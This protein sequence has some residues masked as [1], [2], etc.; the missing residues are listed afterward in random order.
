MTMP[1]RFVWSLAALAALGA[2][3]APPA[4]GQTA[5]G[6]S[7]CDP[8]P[9]AVEPTPAIAPAEICVTVAVL[10]AD[11]MEG[12]LAGSVG[13]EKAAAYL[14]DRFAALGLEAPGGSYLQPFRF[15]AAVFRDP[16][17]AADPATAGDSTIAAANVV[18]I[19]RGRDPALAEQAVVVGA[20]YDHLGW[21]GQ[22]S[23]LPGERA[24][25]N[26]ADDNASGVAGILELA[27]HFRENPPRRTLVFVAFGAEE[28]GTLGSQR[29][30]REPAWPLDRTVAMVNLDMVGRLR[31]RLD[32][33]GTGSSPAW[34]A[35]LDSLAALPGAPEIARVPDGMGPS[36]HASFYVS[37]I[38]VLF[39]FTGAHDDYHRP[40]DDVERIDA[41]GEA[42]VLE[43]A[44]AAIG[45]IAD[46]AEPPAFSE[47][48]ITQ[49]RAVAFNVALGIV[50]DYGYAEGG[51]RVSSVRPG[52]PAELAGLLADDVLVELA[53][54]AVE[55]VYAYT[56]VLGELEAGVS[57]EAVV[58]RG[59]DTVRLTVV[60]EPR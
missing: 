54:R 21:G 43:L 26:G 16:H 27:H 31:E 45:A 11:S 55:D 24:I 38:P 42:R 33:Q 48:P 58:R 50:P 9:P 3:A 7:I 41:G 1:R 53:G 4:S 29:Y 22:G 17:A 14:A 23:L 57:V 13:S 5:E 19:L 15:A 25:H 8:A 49:R 18:A 51:V 10:A 6:S 39:F 40:S 60:P 59:A 56:A 36:D 32:V 2:L 37:R 34:T 35:L 20:H 52:G 28:L 12:R 44:A 30:V 47:A 46:A